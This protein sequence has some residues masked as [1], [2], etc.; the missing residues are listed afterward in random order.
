M[1]IVVQY[2]DSDNYLFTNNKDYNNPNF[3]Y[4]LK[5]EFNQIYSKA[6]VMYW[7]KIGKTTKK[8]RY[9]TYTAYRYKFNKKKMFNFS[10]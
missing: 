10:F 7:G 6:W 2:L 9:S 3:F 4:D 1:T 8:Q 5:P